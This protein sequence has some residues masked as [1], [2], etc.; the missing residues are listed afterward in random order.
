MLAKFLNKRSRKYMRDHAATTGFQRI[1]DA[2]D[3]VLRKTLTRMQ[4]QDLNAHAIFAK[5]LPS[6]SA[7]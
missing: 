5:R 2:A 6:L 4:S 1:E 7:G 3:E